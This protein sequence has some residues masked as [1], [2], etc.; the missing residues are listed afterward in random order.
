MS[1]ESRR[2]RE[3]ATVESDVEL[4]QAWA[5][6]SRQAGATLI[7]RHASSVQRFFGT[8]VSA[9]DLEDL[10]QQTFML[11][12]E[13]RA[14]FRGNGTFRSYL[15]GI[16]RNCLWEHVRRSG[17][18]QALDVDGLS[19]REPGTTP[20]VRL[21]KNR[22]QHELTAAL[23]SLTLEQQTVLELAYW[24]EL[25]GRELAAALGLP[26]N[27]AYARLRRAKLA[28]RE[29]WMQRTGSQDAAACVITME[30]AAHDLRDAR[31][32]GG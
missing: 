5:N 11:G 32:S 15:L 25:D 1:R 17:R 21:Q 9:S 6:G 27:T 10:V 2:E 8:K 19:L 29:A 23:Q 22:E 20:S 7:D 26:I 30:L 12:L 4:L 24:E 3:A 18:A 13:A 28:L 16:A 31:R 14:R